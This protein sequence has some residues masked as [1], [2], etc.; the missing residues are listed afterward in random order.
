MLTSMPVWATIWAVRKE[1]R[2]RKVMMGFEFAR[3]ALR[4][5]N[6]GF[7]I[8]VVMAGVYS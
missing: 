3:R 6:R 8:E 1:G 7:I 5:R 2:P 4:R